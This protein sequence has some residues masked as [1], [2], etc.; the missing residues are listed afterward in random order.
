[1]SDLSQTITDGYIEL[2]V[3]TDA[4]TLQD[5]AIA[6]IQ[7]LL[8][9]YV[10]YE[11][12]LDVI[13]LEELAEMV[14]EA[15]TVF[16]QVPTAILQN[17]G[18]SVVNIPP[19]SGTP[20]GA[21][22]TFTTVDDQGYTVP[23][24]FLVGYQTSGNSVVPFQTVAPL[25]IEAG[26]TSGDVE[27]QATV[28]GAFANGI[29]ASTPLVATQTVSWLL[30]IQA[31][32]TTSGGADPETLTAYLN[33]LST[34]LQLLTPRP[35][36]P[37]DFAVLAQQIAGVY[38]SYAVDLYAGERSCAV[39]PIDIDGN[40]VDST[41]QAA[42]LAYLQSLREVNFVVEVIS[43]TYTDV[44]VTYVVQ[45]LP[46]VSTTDLE[47]TI[48]AALVDMLS[49]AAWAGGGET[50]PVWRIGENIVHYNSVVTTIG[51]QTGVDYVVSCF[52][53]T[54]A[55]PTGTADVTLAGS[56]PLPNIGTPPGTS[57]SGSVLAAS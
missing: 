11:G 5:Q 8:P 28:A 44:Y 1:M 20:A 34:E 37:S 6:A 21:T 53:G 57:I 32:T 30:S 39:C 50:P 4:A 38:R 41:E 29:P 7:A 47:S 19:E 33:R 46:G 23:A 24:G 17:F 43:P 3:T 45:A 22:V 15:A 2:P 35:I 13:L 56:A 31:A 40:A 26:N 36:V 51:S 27:I 12:Q 42:V 48:N 55:A 25:T 16:A 10:P 14:A 18:T 49:P 54:T 52:I 9:G